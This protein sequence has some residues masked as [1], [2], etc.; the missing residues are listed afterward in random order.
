M[1]QQKQQKQQKQQQQQGHLCRVSATILPAIVTLPKRKK[2][3][4]IPHPARFETF[5]FLMPGIAPVASEQTAGVGH[6][7]IKDG[8]RSALLMQRWA[9]GWCKR[10]GVGAVPEYR[11]WRREGGRLQIE[12]EEQ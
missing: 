4:D 11:R 10:D 3:H 9:T 2:L 5:C 12:R 7:G 1:Q 6:A 8:D